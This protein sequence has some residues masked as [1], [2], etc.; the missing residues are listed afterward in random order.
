MQPNGDVQAHLILWQVLRRRPHPPPAL[1]SG[2]TSAVTLLR[3]AGG[4][5]KGKVKSQSFQHF[6][7]EHVAMLLKLSGKACGATPRKDWV[8]LAQQHSFSAA[9]DFKVFC[10]VFLQACR[11]ASKVASVTTHDNKK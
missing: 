4:R 3:L 1:L 7:T 6:A 11:G 9:L 2:E 10:G 5:L 8:L